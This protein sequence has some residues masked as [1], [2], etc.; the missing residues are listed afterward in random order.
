MLD[1]KT[2]AMFDRIAGNEPG[3]LAWLNAELDAT[4]EV[5]AFAQVEAVMRQAQGKA[6]LL[7]SLIERTTRKP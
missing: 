6:Q 1:V 7:R 2:K 3:F 5:L 4:N